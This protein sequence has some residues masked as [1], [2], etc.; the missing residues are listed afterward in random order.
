[1]PT[2]GPGAPP[3]Y[4]SC[5]LRCWSDGPGLWQFSVEDP[6]TGA[7]RGGT[8]MAALVA[9]LDA[10]LRA[11]G[12]AERASSATPTAASRPE[13]RHPLPGC[14]KP[15]SPPAAALTIH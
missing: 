4:R 6:H 12:G 8:E 13:P 10:T 15:G 5:L 7:R 11:E 1:M 9:F 3:R 2:S 14:G